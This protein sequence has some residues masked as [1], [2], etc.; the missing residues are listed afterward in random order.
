MARLLTHEDVRALVSMSDAI[1]A[2]EAAFAE[3]ARG[4]CSCHRGSI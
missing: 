3:E 2:M 1:D 4:R